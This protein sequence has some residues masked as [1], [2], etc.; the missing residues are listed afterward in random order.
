[1]DSLTQIALGIATAEVVAGKELKN[2]VFLYGTILGTLP[3]LDVIVGKGLSPIDAVDFH[4]G[5]SHSLAFFV[6][7]APLLGYLIHKIE[8]SRLSYSKSTQ[9]VFWVLFTHALLD[10]FT[11]WSTQFLWPLEQRFAWKTIFVVDPLYTLPLVIS[12]FFI[13]KSKTEQKRRK[14]LWQGIGISSIYL[15]IT[16]L[17]KLTAVSKFEKALKDSNIDY[18]GLIVK[19]APLNTILWNA[20][21]KT[22]KGFHLADFAFTD[23][24]K[25]VFKEIEQNHTPPIEITESDDFKKLKRIT[26]DWFIFEKIDNRWIMHD[27]RFGF[28]DSIT[29]E[30]VFAISY[31]FYDDGNGIQAREAPKDRLDGKQM[32][33]SI[34]KRMMGN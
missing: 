34:G 30:P 28:Y 8:K 13:W 3:D 24:G 10:L 22:A 33:N 11:T 5:V 6:L 31:E 20:N 1:M 21:V 32:L 23:T 9:M 7:M 15:M 14:L 27:L 19:P 4:R 17:L 16:V 25:I 29:Q 26:E 12:L 18:S 2:R